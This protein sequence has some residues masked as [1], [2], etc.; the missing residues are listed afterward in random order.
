MSKVIMLIPIEKNVGLTTISLGV[1]STIKKENLVTN[2][3]K[4]IINSNNQKRIDHTSQLLKNNSS[5]FIIKSIYQKIYNIEYKKIFF[6]NLIEKI[7]DRYETYKDNSEITLIEGLNIK[8]N[9]IWNKLN[10]KIARILNANIVFVAT[11][12]NKSYLS[13]FEK[14]N[15]IFYLNE[16]VKGIIFNKKDEP[17]FL[18]KVKNIKE[19]DFFYQ[20]KFFLKKNFSKKITC[21]NNV[22]SISWNMKLLE[23][24]ILNIINY[25]NAFIV[26]KKN[27]IN[28]LLIKKIK[29]LKN[30]FNFLKKE[31]IS[32]SL[33]I[34]ENSLLNNFKYHINYFLKKNINFSILVT[35]GNIKKYSLYLSFLEMNIPIFF[36]YLDNYEIL[37]LLKNFH[38]KCSSKDVERIQKIQKYIKSFF[39]KTW[40]K[41]I[42]EKKINSS[43]TISSELFKYNLKKTA[44]SLKKT[45]L[46]PEG[47]DIRIIKSAIQCN[48]LK[49]ANCILLGN[50]NE[51]NNIALSNNIFLNNNVQIID[52][53]TIREK[54][55]KDLIS[56]YK[57]KKIDIKNV[58]DDIKKN[59]VLGML[60][61]LNNVVDG[62]VVGA[63]N[64]TAEVIRSALRIIKMSN[65]CKLISSV[66]FMLLRKNTLIYSDCAINP[67]PTSEQLAEIAI[68]SFNTAKIF[69][70]VPKIAMLSYSTDFS[71]GK[72]FLT[73]K[74]MIAKKILNKKR[75]DIPVEGP[76]QYDAAIEPKISKL[77]FPK[78]SLKGESTIFIFPDLNSGN[79]AYKAVQNSTNSTCIGPILQGMKKPVND[80]S[81]GSS[82]DDIIYTIAATV[83]QSR[84]N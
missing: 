25:I 26:Y 34:I 7:I 60:L 77:K 20:E 35:S 32:N 42:L 78:S 18:K 52:P 53:D 61:L 71:G 46:L 47:N 9:C 28:N 17:C 6:S 37:I 3:F 73:D 58:K 62:V 43:F 16:N 74:I 72:N 5:V 12:K 57:K 81:R 67:N 31:N 8:S 63:T 66:F 41:K 36:T 23:I 40:I 10:F 29:I 44:I 22:V 21:F 24:P 49:I 56:I 65:K 50:I 48:R 33:I 27:K 54:Y 38:F 79:I 51:I 13:Q 1:I 2:F 80:L 76:I 11:Y 15:S 84:K 83:I 19:F 55:K 70:I 45:I 75:P 69:G 4:P 30:N 39:S 68:Q 82:V 59:V 14:K 64:T